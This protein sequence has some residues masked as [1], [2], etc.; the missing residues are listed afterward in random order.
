MLTSGRN[1]RYTTNE[2]YA[3][4]AMC[5][6]PC[7]RPQNNATETRPLLDMEIICARLFFYSLSWSMRCM[8]VWVGGAR[9]QIS[10]ASYIALGRRAATCA[11]G[12]EGGEEARTTS[13]RRESV[14]RV[15]V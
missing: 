5:L 1:G 7:Y 8:C 11:V 10:E 3:S 13:P 2:R 15:L 9:A 6:A 12:M 14:A 4:A